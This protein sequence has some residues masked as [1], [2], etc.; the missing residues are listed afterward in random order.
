MVYVTLTGLVVLVAFL[1]ILLGLFASE[2]TEYTSFEEA[3]SSE[4]F[5]GKRGG[6]LGVTSVILF[7]LISAIILLW[8]TL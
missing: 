5:P 4:K 6:Y 3:S 2:G 1:L 8:G 7:V